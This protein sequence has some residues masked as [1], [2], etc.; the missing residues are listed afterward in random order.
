MASYTD[1]APTF[2]PYVAQQDVDLM[3]KIGMQKQA[4]YQQ[5]YEKIQ[6]SIDKV[7]GLEIYRDVDKAYMQ[8]KLNELGTKLRGVA[9]GDFS[10]FQLTNSVA[11]MAG[12]IVK[13]RN[14]LNAVSST[15]TLKKEQAYAEKEYK[16]GKSSPENQ[17][18]LNKHIQAYVQSGKVGETFNAKYT[19]YIDV[20]KKWTEV[21][22]S[23]HPNATEQDFAYG[24]NGQP[25]ET[26]KRK[27]YE[28]VSKEQ[29][30]NAIRSSFTPQDLNQLKISANYQF[31][32]MGPE[33]LNSYIDRAYS[34]AA[35]E[36]DKE[37]AGL[38]QLAS[39]SSS[40]PE[41]KNKYLKSIEY[42]NKQKAEL[43]DVIQA[44][45][46]RANRDPESAFASIY[47]DEAV[48]QFSN[49]HAWTT[50]KLQE[51]TNPALQEVHWRN[52]QSL[53][54]ANYRLALSKEQFDERMATRKD[55]R[56]ERELEL[57]FKEKVISENGIMGGAVA[58]G[59]ENTDY[60]DPV[61]ALNEDIVAGK[62]SYNDIVL[63]FAKLE[64]LLPGQANFRM[65]KYKEGN[66]DA[67]PVYL[68]KDVNDAFKAKN[69]SDLL[70]DA[71][72]T[73][74]K[75]V[76]NSPLYKEKFAEIDNML[77]SVGSIT[78]QSNGNIIKYSP[79]ELLNFRN[80]NNLNAY[81]RSGMPGTATRESISNSMYNRGPLIG[82]NIYSA[83]K[84]HIS[85]KE[86]ALADYLISNK[87][88]S[89]TINKLLLKLDPI[90][91]ANKDLLKDLNND[92][93]K[94]LLP[95]ISN[96]VPVVYNI[97]FPDKATSNARTRTEGIAMNAALTYD[98]VLA[99]INGGAE[100]F[101]TE[102]RATV[103]GWLAGDSKV[104]DGLQYKKFVSGGKP[105][106]MVVNGTEK[107][108]I[109]LTPELE[110]SLPIN[111][112]APTTREMEVKQIQQLNGNLKTNKGNDPSKSFYQ[113]EDFEKL[114]NLQITGNLVADSSN[115]AQQYLELTVQLP[116]GP[117]TAMSQLPMTIED[118]DTMVKNKMNINWVKQFFTT[119]PKVS[120]EIKKE[121]SNL[122]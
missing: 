99:G 19:P 47:T 117:Y 53:R 24:A 10:N 27:M 109:P 1:K 120:P 104:R 6:N 77:S 58:Y 33:Q 74:Q 118:A 103:Q 91:T 48:K 45:K 46:E 75:E 18:D 66:L 101:S 63:K 29:I 21:Y 44:T 119:N 57:K 69:K 51:L 94:A 111:P 92:V 23:L 97:D 49:S 98:P 67:V 95:K 59:G 13:D 11:G 88:G 89:S 56:E 25:T 35:E 107:V 39:V 68:R 79:K 102:D 16:E 54:E 87:Q 30:E 86:K 76:E 112:E 32:G 42:L 78:I 82:D 40:N 3:A 80:N 108:V 81:M 110:R 121:I 114:S 9:A 15:A 85:A 17:Y 73:T 55:S 7:A 106:L 26:M 61:I 5:G 28:G 8:T 43:P 115:R 37:I 71:L 20:S 122:K 14:V 31:R 60:K 36:L 116:S 105:N 52:E 100:N 90:A 64:N 41:E 4:Q 34:T 70:S 50:K 72:E 62:T 38:T 113:P 93:K 12:E 84:T 96:Y 22:K 65:T 83:Q 2:N